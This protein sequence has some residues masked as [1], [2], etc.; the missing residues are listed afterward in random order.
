[1]QMLSHSVSQQKE[2]A[3]QTAA[4][5]EGLS[6]PGVSWAVQQSPAASKQ[7][8]NP[9][10]MLHTSA[11]SPAQMLS[12]STLQQKGSSWHTFSQHGAKLQPGVPLEEQQSPASAPPQLPQISNASPTQVPSHD[13]AQQNASTS[14]TDLQHASL[15]QPT[16]SWDS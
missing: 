1:A 15:S 5:Q 10:Q 7:T 3:A 11:A 4:Q 8:L 13:I 9:P 2:S 16:E 6:Q 14:Q 12:H